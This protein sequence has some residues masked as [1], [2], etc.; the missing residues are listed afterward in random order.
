MKFDV[1]SML[2]AAMMIVGFGSMVPAAQAWD[3]GM[4]NGMQNWGP[5]PNCSRMQFGGRDGDIINQLYQ[6]GLIS[7]MQ[8]NQISTR[9]QFGWNYT[10]QNMFFGNFPFTP[11]MPS[12]FDTNLINRS[13]RQLDKLCGDQ[14]L[15]RSELGALK[16]Q[17]VTRVKLVNEHPG[18]VY[19]AN[20]NYNNGGNV[21]VNAGNG[22]AGGYNPN[23]NGVSNPSWAGGFNPNRGNG[24][25]WR[26]M[27][28]NNIAPM[29]GNNS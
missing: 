8:A 24:Q 3:N 26:Q 1:K 23:V 6:N 15:S 17:L 4:Q 2:T 5:A 19:G 14:L 21:Y 25:N 18:I 27:F 29:L 9:D 20:P 22:A 13:A 11:G 12:F 7:Q 10:N 28:R 16:N